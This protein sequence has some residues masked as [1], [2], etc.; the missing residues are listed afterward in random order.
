M[1]YYVLYNPKAGNGQSRDCLGKI[2]EMYGNDAIIYDVVSDKPDYAKLV[3]EIAPEDVFVICGGDG[4]INNFV[5]DVADISFDNDVLYYA[6]GT[7]NDF[8]RDV[9]SDGVDSSKPFSIKKY[10]AGLPKVE[11]K[12]KTYRFINGVG[13]GIDGYC[14]EVG[15]KISSA[16][17]T[18]KI[19]Y[20]AIAIKGLLFH[21]KPTSA[22][23]VV[24]GKEYKYDKVWI[25]P[26]MN[27]KRYGGGMIPVPDQD[28]LNNAQVSTMIFH[29]TSKLK[30]LII[31]PSMF[32]GTHVKHTE[33][34]AIHKGKK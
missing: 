27:G 29:G 22:T 32:K 4:T 15:D 18:K 17:S 6:A 34:I 25:A 13:F 33:A 28:R 8:L 30:T 23:V 20:T 24:D 10:I 26:T 7:G 3:S 9:E 2:K 5:N 1:R 12:G 14:C 19:N 31:F 11:V 21:Y 16:D